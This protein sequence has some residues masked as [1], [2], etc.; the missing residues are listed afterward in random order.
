VNWDLGQK[1]GDYLGKIKYLYYPS[2]AVKRNNKFVGVYCE[3]FVIALRA[4]FYKY[5]LLNS[6]IIYKIENTI[7]LFYL[8]LIICIIIDRKK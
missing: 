7:L 1:K 4:S 5:N 3:A 8:Y 6:Y 2:L